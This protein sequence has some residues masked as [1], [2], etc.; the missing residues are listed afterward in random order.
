MKRLD[1]KIILILLN[2][3]LVSFSVSASVTH[4]EFKSLVESF[5]IEFDKEVSSQ[6]ETFLINQDFNSGN[7]LSFYWDM[8]IIRTSYSASIDT[9]SNKKTHIIY[10]FGGYGRLKYMTLDSVIMSLCH[11]LGH[12]LSNGIQKDS[13]YGEP[14]ASVEGEADYFAA[15]KCFKR[16]I[17][18][19]PSQQKDRSDIFSKNYVKKCLNNNEENTKEFCVR[20]YNELLVEQQFFADSIVNPD[21]AKVVSFSS[22]DE[23]EVLR[24]NT[25]PDYY[26]VP[27]CRFDTMING[28]LNEDR[29][30]CW[31]KK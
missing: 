4:N 1:R 12:G 9:K 24:T 18:Y 11:E 26:P 27:Q 30:K 20:S 21:N 25:S 5:H 28:Y 10:F 3:V 31:Y 19:V 6:N 23:S 8:D 16:M 13:S 15:N 7:D 17:K 2:F 14:T 22:P 29:P